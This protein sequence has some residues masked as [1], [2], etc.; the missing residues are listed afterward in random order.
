MTKVL[1]CKDCNCEIK[2]E[3]ENEVIARTAAHVRKD[4]NANS[5]TKDQVKGWYASIVDE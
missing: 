4:H 2:G 5:I 3:N 1:R